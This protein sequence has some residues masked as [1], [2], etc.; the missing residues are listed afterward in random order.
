M[1]RS[2]ISWAP[3]GTPGQFSAHKKVV[4]VGGGLGVAPVYPQLR[5]YKEL[6]AH[7]ISIIGFRSKDLDVLGGQVQGRRATSC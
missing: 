6:G 4:C 1:T 7:T 3:W 5:K 2:T